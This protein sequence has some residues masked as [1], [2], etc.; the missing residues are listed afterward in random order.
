MLIE[1]I[2]IELLLLIVLVVAVFYLIRAVRGAARTAS[3]A[4]QAV[5]HMLPPTQAEREAHFTE[6]LEQHERLERVAPP[7]R[8]RKE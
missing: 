3:R 2:A 6:L 8:K 5:K 4:R 1:R 7:R